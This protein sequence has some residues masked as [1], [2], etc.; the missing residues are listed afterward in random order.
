M[1]PHVYAIHQR[2]EKFPPALFVYIIYR[3][4]REHGIRITYLWVR[5]KVQRRLLGFSPSDLSQILP[6]LYVG[7]QQY[8]H[9]LSRMRAL[10]ITAVVNMREESD[11]VKR[12]VTLDHHLWLPTT[13]D[14]PP[15]IEDLDRGVAFITKHILAGHSVYV[16]CAAGVGRAPTMAVAY[17]VSTGLE[18]KQAWDKLIQARP[19]VR[20][21]LPQLD[22]I[23][24]Y[25][26]HLIDAA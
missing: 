8:K 17:L 26:A 18:P 7:G 11:D 22:I 1:E 15:S 23:E 24:D 9:G 16:H 25:A 12:G 21:T 3:R 6:T 19:F 4:L 5:D 13:D 20:P 10:G 2:L 14:T